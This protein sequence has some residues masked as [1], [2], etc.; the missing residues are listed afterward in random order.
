MPHQVD[1]SHKGAHG[2]VVKSIGGTLSN[3]L[4]WW[5]NAIRRL[6]PWVLVAATLV[7]GSLLYY[8]VNNLG[9][10]TNTADMLSETL[11]FRHLQEDYKKAFPQYS[12]TLVIV[13]EGDTPDLAQDASSSLARHA[14]RKTDLFKTVY[15]PGEGRFFEEHALLYLSPGE[16]ED[17]ADNLAKVQPFLAKLIRDQSLRGL[18]SMLHS[19]VEAI[20]D[21]EEIDLKPIFDRVSAAIEATLNQRYYE[22]SWLE[23]MRGK[24]SIPD[25]RRRLIVVQPRLDYT[26]LLPGETPVKG[27]RRLAKE[28]RLDPEHGIHVRITGDVALEYEEL[29]SVSRGAGIAGLLALI[30]VGMVLFAGL[31]SPRLVLATLVTLVMGLIWT[32]GFATAAVG[33]LNLI[34]VAF[35]VLYIGLSVDY[36]IHFCLRYK[37]LI[38]QGSTHPM[39]LS[40][41]AKDTGSSLVLCA[42]TTAIGF[43]AFIP[44]VFAGVAEL[45]LISGTGMFISLIANLTVL[46]A[47]LSLMPLSQGTM[48]CAPPPG[49]LGGILL[50]LPLRHA[51]T[52]RIGALALGVGALF[53]LPHVRF[54]RN[55]LNL[56]DP[57]SESIV[58]LKE[59]LAASKAPP[60]SLKVLVPDT[61]T[62]RYYADRLNK[63]DLVE[64]SVTLQDFIPTLQ[65][66]KLGIIEEIALI[67][68]PDLMGK[69]R[70]SFPNAS[71]RE[72]SLRGFATSLKTFLEKGSDPDLIASAQRLRD[73][74]GRYEA[75][76]GAREESSKSALLE[77]LERSLLGSLPRRMRTLRASLAAGRVTMQDLPEDVV[78]RWVT[79]DGRHRI[80][81][82][83][84]ENLND[85]KALRRFVAEVQKV[86]PDVIGFPVI[87]LEAGDA[88]VRAFQQAIFL[89][90]ICITV[91]LLI[92]M[93]RKLDT[94]LVLL[95][96]LLAGALTGATSVLLDIPF[97]FANVIALPL[98]LGAGVDNGIHMVHRMRTA[99]PMNGL[100]LKTSTARAVLF[101]ALTTVSSFGTLAVSPH[102]G[103]AS[104]GQLLSIGMGLTLLCTLIVLPTLVKG[105]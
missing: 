59:L 45:G 27:L 25:E 96:L 31:R 4:A 16:L 73:S 23:L 64:R 18:F 28:L 36:A 85:D 100:L 7:T 30:L 97:N 55:T 14:K 99:P 20:L 98:L 91:L 42:L 34:S 70:Q 33:H 52:I 88:V 2:K 79:D 53:I 71:Q 32:A 47:L 78:E 8:T 86:A 17:L 77:R 41:A 76:L 44:T 15:L 5:V 92:L 83:P 50:T 82:F 90:L 101:S 24:E 1:L 19:A 46:P 11:H 89:A 65:D 63:L 74:L 26:K 80:E 95:P 21:G 40:L 13:V 61:K 58:T 12:D 93:R 22:L 54:D 66:K 81:V 10:N 51:L 104:M 87:I 39:A 72:A 37:E 6:A 94:L 67:V 60:W 56:R 75:A 49:H 3:T 43:Y 29:R 57:E 103:M 102:R 38:G 48:S 62:A 9:I 69:I 35:A 84:R 105:E 68:G